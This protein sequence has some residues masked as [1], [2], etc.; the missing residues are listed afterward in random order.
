MSIEKG[1]LV[2]FQCPKNS[3]IVGTVEDWDPVK[4][5][6]SCRGKTTSEVVQKLKEDQLM[7]TREELLDEDVNDLLH[8]TLLHDSTILNVLKKRYMSDV[9]YTNIGAI[10]VALNPF[11]F[12]IPWYTDDN[13]PKYLAE[14]DRIET[15]LPHSWAV[16]HNTYWEMM[17]D[18]MNQCILVSGE[19]GAGKTEASKIVMKYLAA[20]SCKSG[21][22]AQKTA[23]AA[24]G[25]KINLASPPL[26][27]YG[28]A[29]T[30][31][32]DNSSRFG[33]FMKVKFDAQGFLM[34][35]HIT[36][37]LLEKSRIVTASPGERVYHSFYL[38]L[39]GK[40]TASLKL[41]DQKD[42]RSVSAGKQWD[43]KEFNT[44]DEYDEVCTAMTTIGIDDENIASMWKTV[45]GIL[46]IL[47]V[48]FEADGEGSIL[49]PSA[50]KCIDNTV[51][52]WEVDKQKMQREFVS[53][54]LDVGGQLITKLLT[55]VKAIDGRDALVKALYD[56]EF[57]WLVTKC[58]EIL[59]VDNS[60]CWI[61]L[62]DIFGF[63]DFEINSFEQFCINLANE[64]LQGHYNQFIFTRDMEEC[65]AEGIDVA[66]VE[67]P[68]NSPCLIMMVGKGGI[69]ALLD[70]ECALGKGT[71]LGFLSKI[72]D[73][74]SK[75]EFFQKKA[76]DRTT[77]TIHHYAGSVSYEVEGFLEKNRDTL[78]D[79]MKLLM[80]ASTN[81]FIAN[82]LPPPVE[83]SGPKLT[84]GGFFKSQLKDLMDL[85][86]STNPHWI[87]CVKPHPA[88]KPLHFDGVSTM[89]QLA[90]AGVLGT[91]K[92][93]KAGFP[94]R[95]RF[96]DFVQRYSIIKDGGVSADHRTAAAEIIAASGIDP[97]RAQCGNTRAFL[98][99]DAYVDL[100]QLKRE[101]LQKHARVVQ[102]F[103][104]ALKP[105]QAVKDQV[106]VKNK[107]LVER[108]RVAIKAIVK[109][110]WEENAT[111]TAIEKEED[112]LF[113]K[114]I[115]QFHATSR[116]IDYERIAALEREFEAAQA[117]E[118][119]ELEEEWEEMRETLVDDEARLRHGL[120]GIIYDKIARARQEEQRRLLKKA[121]E[122]TKAAHLARLEE[123][124][125]KSETVRLN[126][127]RN[128]DKIKERSQREA[129][130]AAAAEARRD[131]EERKRREKII[132]AELK[133]MVKEEQ[134]QASLSA[135]GRLGGGKVLNPQEKEER[136][137]KEWQRMEGHRRKMKLNTYTRQTWEEM[138]HADHDYEKVSAQLDK[139]EKQR[140]RE[141]VV[142][143][144]EKE[145][146][147]LEEKKKRQLEEQLRTTREIERI[148]TKQVDIGA[149]MVK[150]RSEM[151]KRAEQKEW[152]LLQQYFR[153][154]KQHK[155]L[156][157]ERTAENFDRRRKEHMSLER[158]SQM[159]AHDKGFVPLSKRVGT[160]PPFVMA[161]GVE[162]VSPRRR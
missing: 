67:F 51:S 149:K 127:S 3:W 139:A 152:Q 96:E 29:R 83:R 111:R 86:N 21:S 147:A 129:A 89:H 19:S 9:I 55:P 77:F 7:V 101:K 13:M 35:A 16:A 154:E 136:D 73:A 119:F 102:A 99:S 11:N 120:C 98:K 2:Y 20:L 78:K 65:R 27:S 62:L 32:N 49:A 14:G 66:D 109:A 36:K 161:N 31:R 144:R 52:L 23:A 38:V 103:I 108:L 30:V 107:E 132:S 50:D 155:K 42:Y 117:D 72:T 94:V 33:K 145:R 84:V 6:G 58:N 116:E 93:R 46:H 1:V 110:D 97:K 70:E 125:R 26:E 60:G 91:V 39:R 37:Y 18:E 148:R 130:R 57:G 128:I 158:P 146:R 15:N 8:L 4:K 64:T 153:N 156:E 24:V 80:R 104:S 44:S 137:R 95:I 131:E 122:A 81:N 25:Q 68:D 59:D 138:K 71:D 140:E 134:Y 118:R 135:K 48:D 114:M 133:M 17:N 34:G 22:D 150:E 105:I 41:T 115:N 40:D 28:N 124:Q 159:E 88:K 100:E 5:I 151:R 160:A 142:H 141:M 54:E 90:S 63:E 112:D 45:A 74:C 87:R 121:E 75:N 157:K 143:Q 79:A 69:S 56:Q 85:I 76:L 92:I 82:L 126:Q 43:N 12:K 106:Y 53:T 47:N 61:G 113:N 162:S 123:R 10:V